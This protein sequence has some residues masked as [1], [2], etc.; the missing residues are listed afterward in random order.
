MVVR[1]VPAEDVADGF[2]CF[3]NKT[4]WPNRS[5]NGAPAAG[6]EACSVLDAMI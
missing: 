1:G 2:H 5:K 6:P 3:M 4:L